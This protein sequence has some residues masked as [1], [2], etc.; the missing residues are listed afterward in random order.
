MLCMG[1][2]VVY[3]LNSF[4]EIFLKNLK[5]QITDIRYFPNFKKAMF[6]SQKKFPCHYLNEKR[7]KTHKNNGTKLFSQK[8]DFLFIKS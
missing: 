3:S 8:Q 7:K 6:T 4:F 2:V 1:K 5:N